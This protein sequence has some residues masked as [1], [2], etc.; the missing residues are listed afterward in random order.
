MPEGKV[1]KIAQLKVI[2]DLTWNV[3]ITILSYLS[4]CEKQVNSRT[5][6]RQAN[7]R[8]LLYKK[9]QTPFLTAIILPLR[10]VE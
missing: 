7:V 1:Y 6:N 3:L 5:Q 8:Q 10:H 9:Q 2:F 4:T